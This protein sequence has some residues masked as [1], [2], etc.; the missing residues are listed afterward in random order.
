MLERYF[1]EISFL[2]Q[3]SLKRL[4]TYPVYQRF[5]RNRYIIFNLYNIQ[6]Y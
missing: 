6:L 3:N 2:D 5:E 1:K 4:I